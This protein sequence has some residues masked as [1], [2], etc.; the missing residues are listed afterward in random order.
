VNALRIDLDDSEI[1]FLE[2][3]TGTIAVVKSMGR[4]FYLTSQ[5][6]EV[7]IFTN[8]YDLIVASTFGTG[9]KARRALRCT[10]FQVRE[11][12][13]PLIVLPKGHRATKRLQ[14]VLSLGSRTRLSCRIEPGTHPEQD[15][16]CGAEEF[17][18]LEITATN[19]GAEV[20]GFAGRSWNEKFIL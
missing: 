15:V 17:H 10:L 4:S 19:G 18:G 2:G 16:L 9:E 13:M 12:D 6:D 20:N 1:A 5:D 3:C 11:M 7:V 14:T 8:E